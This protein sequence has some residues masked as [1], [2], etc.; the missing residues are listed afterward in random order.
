MIELTQLNLDSSLRIDKDES[1]VKM[2]RAVRSMLSSHHRSKICDK[3]M[4]RI[5]QIIGTKMVLQACIISAQGLGLQYYF[6]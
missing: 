3:K 4:E 5:L 6:Y 1:K 2:I